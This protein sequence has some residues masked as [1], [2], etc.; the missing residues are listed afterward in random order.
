MPVLKILVFAGWKPARHGGELRLTAS[1]RGRVPDRTKPVVVFF[2]FR[3][4]PLSFVA[5]EI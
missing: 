3:R 2:H 1:V 4:R 5:R